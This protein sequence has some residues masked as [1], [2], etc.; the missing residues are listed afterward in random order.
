MTDEE[1]R[2]LLKLL[3]KYQEE[4]A[5]DLPQTIPALAEDLAQSLDR[6][7]DEDDLL[8]IGIQEAWNDYSG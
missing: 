5:P 1:I 7:S 8:S 3:H 2:Q 6:T 4:Y